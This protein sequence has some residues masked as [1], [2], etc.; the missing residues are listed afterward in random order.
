[1]TWSRQIMGQHSGIDRYRRTADEHQWPF[2]PTFARNGVVVDFGSETGEVVTASREAVVY[3]WKKPTYSDTTLLKSMK[4]PRIAFD[5]RQTD[6]LWILGENGVLQA[7][8]SRHNT[9]IAEIRA[10]EGGANSLTCLTHSDSVLTVGNDGCCRSWQLT[11]DQH[12]DPGD[13]DS[14]QDCA[15]LSVASSHDGKRIASVDARAVLHVWD[16]ESG[17]HVSETLLSGPDAERPLTGAVA[18]NADDS[19][20]AAYGSGT[21]GRILT[22]DSVPFRSLPVAM[23]IAGEGGTALIWSGDSPGIVFGADSFPRFHGCRPLTG[24]EHPFRVDYPRSPCVAMTE[25]SRGTRWFLL[26]RTGRVIVFDPEFHGRIRDVPSDGIEE[27][28]ACDVA[29]DAHDAR[30][31]VARADGTISIRETAPPPLERRVNAQPLELSWICT[32]LTSPSGEDLLPGRRSVV[33]D[34]DDHV[35]LL[36]LR[37]ST[38][39]RD[40]VFLAESADGPI[41]EWIE[42]VG[43]ADVDNTFSMVFARSHPNDPSLPALNGLPSGKNISGQIT[44][45]SRGKLTAVYRRR[46][47]DPGRQKNYSSAY[48]AD[49]HL[50]QRSGPGTW[51]IEKIVDN[52][53]TGF[54]PNAVVRNG[55]VSEVFCFEYADM[56]WQH[57]VRTRGQWQTRSVGIRG[58]GWDALFAQSN[59]GEPHFVFHRN[60]PGSDN[61]PAVYAYRDDQH[62]R[63]QVFDPRISHPAGITT[64]S[65]GTVGI[66][67]HRLTP[68]YPSGTTMLARNQDNRWEFDS[69]PTPN[70]RS[71]SITTDRHG[72]ICVSGCVSN[73]SGGEELVFLRQ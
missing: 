69:L 51:S 10:H 3:V 20:I 1:M 57:S 68:G 39:K 21:T 38:Q 33:L 7:F 48:S 54:F 70:L 64:L 44:R 23:R 59:D 43:P 12:I 25:D 63:R 55:D 53:N 35:S 65:A 31:A 67:F 72:R 61:G 37:G 58:D 34:A 22:T 15:L 71:A 6:V 17:Q 27:S 47:E 32:T 13:F 36:A 73:E 52:R 30:L 28:D 46:S 56:T 5:Q 50:A 14:V 19:L 66:L 11:E 45:P 2:P 24:E 41:E 26:E 40:L 49:L 18:F 62:I 4:R 42:H 60:R 8:D 16:V 29:I 9:L